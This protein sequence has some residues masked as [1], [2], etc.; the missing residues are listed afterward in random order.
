[1]SVDV[2]LA[3]V[4]DIMDTIEPVP[5]MN[6]AAARGKGVAVLRL[7]ADQGE[8]PL[9]P[10]GFTSA[11]CGWTPSSSSPSQRRAGGISMGRNGVLIAAASSPTPAPA[12]RAQL[13]CRQEERTRAW[14]C[15]AASKPEL[16][17]LCYRAPFTQ[18]L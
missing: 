4:S 18:T 2:R 1:M 6:F 3:K 16:V 9:D 7:A 10:A 14:A 12:P 11:R 5:A 15:A 17:A 8:L 13:F